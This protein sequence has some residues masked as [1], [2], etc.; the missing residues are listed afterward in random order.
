VAA[1][2]LVTAPAQVQLSPF[3]S[4]PQYPWLGTG[5]APTAQDHV[6]AQI[7]GMIPAG[8]SVSAEPDLFPQLADR[9]NAYPYYEPGT[10]YL[11]VNIDS[12]WFTSPM[13]QPDPPLSWYDQLRE[14]ITEEYGVLASGDGGLL[15][16]AGYTGS[17]QFL[18]PDTTVIDPSNVTLVNATYVAN[19]TAPLGAYIEPNQTLRY[20]SLWTGPDFLIPPGGYLLNVYLR[21]TGTAN[22]A[23]QLS[24]SIDQGRIVIDKTTVPSSSLSDRWQV[25][26]LNILVGHP[27]YVS[28]D[29]AAFANNPTVQFGGATLYQQEA[30]SLLE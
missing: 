27:A 19:G 12:F 23:L 13:P 8:A 24:V 29:G 6:L 18:I 28:L 10:R 17:P 30:T 25:L 22:G 20:G 15:Y 7:L 14:N 5:R 21:N 11:V 1:L 9:L 3:S 26:S 2:I 4:V 16:E